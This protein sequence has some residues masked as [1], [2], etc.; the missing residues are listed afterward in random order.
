M[1]KF[2]TQKRCDRF[3]GSL[4]KGRIMSMFNEECICLVCNERETKQADYKEAVEAE[5][6][7]VSRGNYN[8]KGIKGK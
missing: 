1:D 2:F 5:H 8:F 4:E 7:E 3:G 6:S